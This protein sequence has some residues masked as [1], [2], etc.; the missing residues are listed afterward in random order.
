MNRIPL[1]VSPTS[2]VCLK[3]V[4][5]FKLH[6]LPRLLAEGLVV[7]L[8]SDDPPMF[9]TTLT[10]EYMKAADAFGFT[11]E[12]FVRFNRT[13]LQVS[14]LPEKQKLELSETMEREYQEL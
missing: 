14:L 7:T 2:N 6:P 10:N 9:N 5:E 1:E 8:N 13:T 3:V 12:D 11:K 4:P